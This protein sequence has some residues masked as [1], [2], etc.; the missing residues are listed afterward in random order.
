MSLEGAIGVRLPGFDLD[1][2]VEVAPGELLAIL[3][4]NGAGKTTL[5]RSITGLTALDHGRLIVDGVALDDP[6]A[7][8]FV[9]VE[10]RPVGMVFQ[11]YLLFDH[12]TAVENVAFGLRARGVP[13]QPARERA[14]AWLERV[15]LAEHANA[16]PAS[17]SGGQAQRVALARALATEP[18]VLLLDEPL[19]ALDVQTRREVRRD[20]RDHL[21][22]FDGM[23]LLVTHDP[24][25]AYALADRVA[26][27]DHGRVAQSGT[28]AQVTAHPRSRYVADLVGTNL[29][30]GNVDG[31]TL[32][33]DTGAHVVVADAPPGRSFA[34][35]RP[36]AVVLSAVDGAAA[37]SAR[38]TWLGTV[39]DIDILGDRARVD[40][41]GALPLIAEVTVAAVDALGLRPGD[42]VQA[43]VKATD[44]ET[45][46]A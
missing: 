1:V 22:S 45:Y 21:A 38:N 34:V 19:A 42:E 15:G 10:Q 18:R 23:R 35:I 14:L 36:R 41:T 25:D 43:T 29:V 40:I 26:I 44:I 6:A 5:L 16:N 9:A 3:G 24:V 2:E 27:L 32:L 28:I 20:L 31:G 8:V 33:T 46:P 17:L 39:R 13:R 4:P 11:T 30:V 7:D 37:T 12:L